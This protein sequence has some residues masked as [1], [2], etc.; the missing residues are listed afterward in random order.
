M[1]GAGFGGSIGTGDGGVT[2]VVVAWPKPLKSG[3]VVNGGDD[4]VGA[5]F[6]TCPNPEK[7]GAGGGGGD[8]CD[9]NSVT[10]DD[11]TWPNPEKIGGVLVSGCASGGGLVAVEAVT[12]STVLPFAS[13]NV[14][15]APFVVKAYPCAPTIRKEAH[16][17]MV[18]LNLSPIML[19]TCDVLVVEQNPWSEN[20]ELEA[21]G[22]VKDRRKFKTSK[23]SRSATMMLSVEAMRDWE[24]ERLLM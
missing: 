17:A 5:A 10:A 19:V 9:D 4:D 3:A 16:K 21:T 15:P 22:N 18:A 13:P 2:L 14:L 7:T 11:V 20:L 8:D 23:K 1:T 24:R 6:V 12:V